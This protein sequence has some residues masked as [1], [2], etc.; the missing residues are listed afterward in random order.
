M[1]DCAKTLLLRAVHVGDE[2]NPRVKP[3][4][5]HLD[6]RL[7]TELADRCYE[8]ALAH[9]TAGESADWLI[10]RGGFYEWWREMLGQAVDRVLPGLRTDIV[11]YLKSPAWLSGL[12]R[13][14]PGSS[15]DPGRRLPVPQIRGLCT[16]G[17]AML[18]RTCGWR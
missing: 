11:K 9:A 4:G 14:T 12:T 7:L 10:F 15:S 8:Y 6:N 17:S 16:G 1:N 5:H 13:M 18:A 3:R 2:H